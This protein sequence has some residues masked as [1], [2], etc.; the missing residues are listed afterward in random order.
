MKKFL[1]VDDR[2]DVREAYDVLINRQYKNAIIDH[3]SDG[4]EGFQKA[5]AGDYSI[6]IS[7]IDMPVM[8]GIEFYKKLKLELSPIEKKIIFVSGQIDQYKRS[9]L[10][11][12][13]CHFLYK[14]FLTKDLLYLIDSV[15]EV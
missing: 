9:F 15:I 14:P 4:L 7:D 5:S 13:G 12:E 3:A 1:I 8:N 2:T 11:E 6:I 10:Q